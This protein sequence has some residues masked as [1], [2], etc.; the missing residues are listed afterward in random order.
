M[1]S[2]VKKYA[3]K[4]GFA[5]ALA[6]ALALTP[7][8]AA[9]MGGSGEW[10]VITVT[11]VCSMGPTLGG[12]VAR[13]VNR[14]VGTLVAVLLA[15]P[16]S[17]LGSRASA[18][19]S[20]LIALVIVPSILLVTAS[21]YW[22]MFRLRAAKSEWEYSAVLFNLS[23]C[24]LLHAN[25]RDGV[26]A[27]LYR[28][29]T[30]VLGGL[31]AL[32]AAGVWPYL[33]S[34]RLDA[35]AAAALAEAARL[36]RLSAA[37][38]TA[39]HGDG[40]AGGLFGELTERAPA[41]AP[42]SDV[43]A[44][45]AV[46]RSRQQLTALCANMRHS[47]AFARWEPR[48]AGLLRSPPRQC[49]A[50]IASA[51]VGAD[52]AVASEPA[53]CHGGRLVVRARRRRLACALR[54]VGDGLARCLAGGSP[55]PI[56]ESYARFET[57]LADFATAAASLDALGVSATQPAPLSPTASQPSSPRA[58]GDDG[59]APRASPSGVDETRAAGGSAHAAR[60]VV[61]LLSLI[62]I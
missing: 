50:Q 2:D 4:A 59:P 35:E 41:A 28:A 1:V 13:S 58:R 36:V 43:D 45:S 61:P 31:L 42:A 55:G 51:P 32:L 19:A 11:V 52:D 21:T 27:S 53:R 46:V 56:L 33:A 14:G 7:A 25:H 44:S 9:L 30:I 3:L 23:F 40:G 26:A 5:T 6:S 29:G 15:V 57:A 8:T 48:R 38:F 62:H 24:M 37:K 22:A 34:D 54:S 47:M 17:L 16:I 10:V 20:Q 39:A 49:E 60:P 18:L 12:V